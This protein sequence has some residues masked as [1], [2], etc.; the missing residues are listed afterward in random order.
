MALN[1]EDG[2]SRRCISVQLP[3]PCAESSEA[4]RA[5]FKTIA[6]IAKERIRRA[7]AKIRG[8]W[9]EKNAA[10][11]TAHAQSE[12]KKAGDLFS[13]SASLAASS[14][15]PSPISNPFPPDTGFRVF[16]LAPSNFKRWDGE[17]AAVSKEA[18]EQQ[19]EASLDHIATGATEE[20]ILFEIL[21][22]AGSIS[23]PARWRNLSWP[24]TRFMPST[25][26]R[27][28][29]AWRTA[30]TRSSSMP[31]RKSIRCSSSASTA[32]CKGNDPLKVN[33]LETFRA[34]QPEIQFRTV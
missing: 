30:S 21:L 3:E 24:G 12:E 27:F 33:T 31:L 7:G 16:K 22:K 28:S 23:S 1:A 6:D 8:E 15:P 11:E 9:K 34:A 19:M 29:S 14:H 2:G 18:L 4:S 25:A 5:G 26:T 13:E 20:S 17:A 32:R 10:R